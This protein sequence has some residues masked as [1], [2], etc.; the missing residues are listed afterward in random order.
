MK[1]FNG[2]LVIILVSYYI[3]YRLLQ[4]LL[5]NCIKW[6]IVFFIKHLVLFKRKNHVLDSRLT[7]SRELATLVD[8]HLIIFLFFKLHHIFHYNTALWYS[9]FYVMNNLNNKNLKKLLIFRLK[10][11]TLMSILYFISCFM[12]SIRRG[13]KLVGS[14]IEKW[15]YRR[16]NISKQNK[17]LRLAINLISYFL[18]F[19]VTSKQTPLRGNL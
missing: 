9:C 2:S 13:M 4:P 15:Y 14:Q 19:H 3:L 17:S 6:C 16:L 11:L 8:K 1:P 12:N 7:E 5:L 10:A 18:P